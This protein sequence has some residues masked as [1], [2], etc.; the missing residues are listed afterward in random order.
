MFSEYNCSTGITNNNNTV[1]FYFIDNREIEF[2][3]RMRQ[4]LKS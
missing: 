3:I 4:G 2:S 1:L